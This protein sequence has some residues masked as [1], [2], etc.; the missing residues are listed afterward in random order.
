MAGKY[1]ADEITYRGPIPDDILTTGVKGKLYSLYDPLETFDRETHHP[2]DNNQLLRHILKNTDIDVLLK[3]LG[4]AFFPRQITVGASPLITPLIEPNRYPRGYILI[5]PNQTVSGVVTTVT[6]FP[7]A[8]VFPV[9]VT[10]SASINVEGHRTARFFLN[11]TEA[12]AGPL[13]VDAQSQDPISGNWTTVQ[14]DIFGGVVAVGTY[15][16]T[17]GEIGV[18]QNMRLQVTVAGDTMTGSI[19]GI[20]KEAFGSTIAGPTVFLGNADVNTTIGYPLLAGQR[21]TIY[22]KENTPLF[23]IA[24]AATDLR[25]FELQ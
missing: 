18:D 19:A 23:G 24:V 6:V 15:Y 4:N 20:L 10:N 11:I 13:T 2:L 21:E 22:L 16:A 17:I 9:G 3:T 14:A 7:A 12:T 8:T 25:L 1:L 5:N